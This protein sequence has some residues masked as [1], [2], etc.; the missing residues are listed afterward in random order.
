MRRLNTADEGPS[1]HPELELGRAF[2][3]SLAAKDFSALEGLLHPNLTFRGL[4]PGKAR[5][6]WESHE[7]NSVIAD[8]LRQWFEPTDRIESLLHTEVDR[9]GDRNRVSYR[10]SVSNPDGR[11]VVEQQAYYSVADG[12]I[13]WMSVVCSGFRPISVAAEWDEAS[14]GMSIPTGLPWGRV[15]MATSS[16]VRSAAKRTEAPH[17]G[18]VA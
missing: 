2:A 9:V 11:F 7:V 5:Y 14:A 3:A 16:I 12:K 6:L 18:G 17:V 10:L 13:V 8:I 1:S 15:P 4:T